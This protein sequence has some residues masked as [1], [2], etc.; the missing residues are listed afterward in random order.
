MDKYKL[1]LE[2][3]IQTVQE[4]IAESQ[5]IMYRNDIENLTFTAE[6]DKRHQKEVEINNQTLKDKLDLLWEELGRLNDEEKT[7]SS[8]SE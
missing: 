7:G 8:S 1:P 3:R 5:K 2:I 6:G 4:Q